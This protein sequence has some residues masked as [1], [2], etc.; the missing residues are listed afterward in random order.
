MN[1]VTHEKLVSHFSRSFNG[2]V[3]TM[4]D[5]DF[6]I[7]MEDNPDLFCTRVQQSVPYAHK[8]CLEKK[9]KRWMTEFDIENDHRL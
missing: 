1:P 6:R 3:Y 2:K 7:H 4:P 8:K 5:E 9:Q